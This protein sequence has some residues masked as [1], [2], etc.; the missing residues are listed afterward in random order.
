LSLQSHQD[1]QLEIDRQAMAKPRTLTVLSATPDELQTHQAKL[2]EIS[3]K[4]GK[5]CIW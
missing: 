3:E 4:S 1:G 2:A 5:H